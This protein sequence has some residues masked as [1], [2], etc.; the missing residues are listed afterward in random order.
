[1]RSAKGTSGI[2][3]R[4]YHDAQELSEVT[5]PVAAATCVLKS[6]CR[7][8]AEASLES[9]SFSRALVR[10]VGA[11]G[12]VSRMLD[13]SSGWPGI[14]RRGS[15]SPVDGLCLRSSMDIDVA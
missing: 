10:P 4:S 12:D 2:F 11:K 15:W 1:L 6:D 9:I 13:G 5:P 14:V 3:G 7:A 8:W